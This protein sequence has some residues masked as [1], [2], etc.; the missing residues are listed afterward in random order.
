MGIGAIRRLKSCVDSTTLLSVYNALVQPH[1]D[2]CC[3]VWDSNNVTSSSC[4]E[5]LYNRTARI[6]TDCPNVHSQSELA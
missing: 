1:F 5:Q 6:I 2:Y 4:L 3:E